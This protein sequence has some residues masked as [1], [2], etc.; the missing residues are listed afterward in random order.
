MDNGSSV[1][2]NE[3]ARSMAVDLVCDVNRTASVLCDGNLALLGGL[4]VP[5]EVFE[6]RVLFEFLWGHLV[7][8]FFGHGG[9]IQR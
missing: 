6:F 8:P 3:M 1:T 4:Q 2:Y 7:G 5:Y 9:Y